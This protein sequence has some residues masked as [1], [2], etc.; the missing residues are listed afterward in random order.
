MKIHAATVFRRPP[1]RLNCAQ[2]VLDAYQTVT[3]RH[4]APVIE[5]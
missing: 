1:E 4:V 5:Y 3:G 2:A